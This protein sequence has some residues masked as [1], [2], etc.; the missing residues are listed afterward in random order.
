MRYEIEFVYPLFGVGFEIKAIFEKNGDEMV[1]AEGI[2][3]VGPDDKCWYTEMDHFSATIKLPGRFQFETVSI[4]KLI[5]RTAF[6]ELEKQ[7]ERDEQ[8]AEDEKWF[9]ENEVTK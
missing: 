7:I 9:K 8:D 1:L 5:K 6:V 4:A 3:A 2:D